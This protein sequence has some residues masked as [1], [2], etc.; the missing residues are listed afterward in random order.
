MLV[1]KEIPYLLN[2][3]EVKDNELEGSFFSYAMKSELIRFPKQVLC[4]RTTTP[5]FQIS[6]RE[7]PQFIRN[8]TSGARYKHGCISSSYEGAPKRALP[9]S[10]SAGQR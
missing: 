1:W 4:K 6:I 8:N 10:H 2:I 7:S 9:K 3:N 5:T